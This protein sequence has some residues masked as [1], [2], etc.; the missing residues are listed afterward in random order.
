LGGCRTIPPFQT[1]EDPNQG[2]I[3][4]C[5]FPAPAWKPFES[6][7][8]RISR[9]EDQAVSFMVWQILRRL[10]KPLLFILM[11]FLLAAV[12]RA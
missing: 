2:S 4:G 5:G 8:S 12:A 9:A 7:H 11:F 3:S 10:P 1:P 6:I